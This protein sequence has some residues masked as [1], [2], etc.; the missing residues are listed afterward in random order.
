MLTVVL[1]IAA[2]AVVTIA[3]GFLEAKMIGY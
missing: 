1:T 3:L 2:F